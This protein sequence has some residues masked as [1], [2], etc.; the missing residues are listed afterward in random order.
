MNE[1]LVSKSIKQMIGAIG[2][3]PDREGL[4][5]TPQRFA[6]AMGF[7]CSG[8]SQ[9]PVEVLN[10]AIF[11]EDYNEMIVVRDI[12][13]YSLCEHHLLPF[14]GKVHIAYIPNGK[15]VGL[16]KLARIAEIYARRLQVQERLTE[17]IAT[18]LNET[19]APKGVGV[20][21]EAKH[22]C[23]VMRGVQ[24]QNSVMLTSA[25]LGAFQNIATRQEF[26]DLAHNTK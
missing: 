9:N 5:K 7:L 10:G 18:C 12:E 8:Y 15:I 19:L 16:S 24:K 3:D 22:M 6:K 17:Q 14:F 4:Q 1:G 21:V 11:H 2:E 23:M 13:I 26:L 20:I 25:M